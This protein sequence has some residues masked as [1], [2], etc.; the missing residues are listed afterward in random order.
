MEQAARRLHLVGP[1]SQLSVEE[2]DLA[3]LSAAVRRRL[4]PTLEASYLRGR[5]AIRDAI[6][7]ALRCSEYQAEDLVDTL[8]LQGFV[9]FPHLPD[10]THPSGR[11]YWHIR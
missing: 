4:G 5:T 8:E 10:D 11:R 2:I 7:D 6:T 9:R 1:M 3:A